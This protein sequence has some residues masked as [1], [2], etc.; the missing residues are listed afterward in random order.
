MNPIENVFNFAKDTL[1]QQALDQNITFENMEQ[2]SAQVKHTL[3]N[4]SIAYLNKTINS[5]D[6][7][8]TLVTKSGGKCRR[9]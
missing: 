1:H 2:Y 3:E 9:Y 6:K 4:I 8:T 7:R 5:M